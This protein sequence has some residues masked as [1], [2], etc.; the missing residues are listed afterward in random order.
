[1][2]YLID[3]NVC[4]R[5]MNGR[6]SS[7]RNKICSF[8]PYD[9][10]VCSIVRAELFYGARKSDFPEKTLEKLMTFLTPFSTLAFDD[11]VAKERARNNFLV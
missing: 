7:V 5:Y 10:V 9:I 2:K 3:T 4:I 1:V 6:S 8:N 11:T